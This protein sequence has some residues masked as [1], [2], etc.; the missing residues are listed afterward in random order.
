MFPPLI[1]F[2]AAILAAL[3]FLMVLPGRRPGRWLEAAAA[4]LMGAAVAPGWALWWLWATRGFGPWD[5]EYL[6]LGA[7][8]GGPLVLA[9][10]LL[11]AA[12]LRR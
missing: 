9:S 1:F 5:G 3:A 8:W 11:Q 12:A 6:V 2:W 4:A 7:L 10:L